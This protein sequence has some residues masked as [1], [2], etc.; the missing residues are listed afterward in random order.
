VGWGVSQAAKQRGH[1]P[2]PPRRLARWRVWAATERNGAAHA[3]ALAVRRAATALALM[4]RI[5]RRSATVAAL[6]HER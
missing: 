2:P 4:A 6:Q 1:P 3:H 5:V